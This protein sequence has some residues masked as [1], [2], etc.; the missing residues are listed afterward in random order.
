MCVSL[1]VSVPFCLC[2]FVFAFVVLHRAIH[3]RLTN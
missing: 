2:A 1:F 3:A